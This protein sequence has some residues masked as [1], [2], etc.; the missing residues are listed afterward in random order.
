MLNLVLEFQLKYFYFPKKD[1]KNMKKGNWEK[2][3][4]I[5]FKKLEISSQYQHLAVKPSNKFYNHYQQLLQRRKD[6][7]L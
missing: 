5:F 2:K 7:N 1:M 6:Q 4:E 3:L